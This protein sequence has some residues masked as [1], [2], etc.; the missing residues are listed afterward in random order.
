MSTKTGRPS[1]PRRFFAR[2]YGHLESTKKVNEEVE[3]SKSRTNL[4]SSTR[5][6]VCEKSTNSGSETLRSSPLGDVIQVSVSLFFYLKPFFFCYF[7]YFFLSEKKF[8]LFK[9]Y[10]RNH[11]YVFV[12]IKFYFKKIVFFSSKH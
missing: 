7:S 2:I 11:L 3:D 12:N 9:K 6:N 5:V 1:S 8:F 10:N 4:E